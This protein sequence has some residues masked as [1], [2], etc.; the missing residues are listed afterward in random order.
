ML[1]SKFKLLTILLS[2]VLVWGLSIINVNAGSGV[3]LQAYFH[4]EGDPAGEL[5]VNLRQKLPDQDGY[6]LVETITT[7]AT[8]HLFSNLSAELEYD[9]VVNDVANY[10]IAY[11]QDNGLVNVY[12]NKIYQ[13]ELTFP[14]GQVE[15]EANGLEVT[16]PYPNFD[17]VTTLTWPNGQTTP[18]ANIMDDHGKITINGAL[19]FPIDQPGLYSLTITQVDLKYQNFS[20]DDAL[21]RVDYLVE[22]TGFDLSVDATVVFKDEAIAPAI[23]FAN[24]YTTLPIQVSLPVA[25]AT[26]KPISQAESFQI[27]LYDILPFGEFLNT[28]VT[29]DYPQ[30]SSSAFSFMMWPGTDY[31]VKI[32]QIPNSSPYY[33]Y[34]Q[35]SYLVNLATDPYGLVDMTIFDGTS[36]SDQIIFTNVYQPV[37]TEVTVPF[38]KQILNYPANTS[39]TFEFTLEA[40]D[41]QPGATIKNE[42]VALTS[43]GD[44]Q[45]GAFDLEF[46]EPGTYCFTLAESPGALDNYRYDNSQYQLEAIVSDQSGY[47]KVVANYYLANQAVTD[48]VFTNEYH[49]EPI[50]VPDSGANPGL[51]EG[52]ELPGGEQPI[53]DA[54]TPAITTPPENVVENETGTKMP[55]SNAPIIVT[56]DIAP[57]SINLSLLTLG[58][59]ALA[60]L[61]KP[62][63][64]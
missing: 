60:W 55:S 63:V 54:Q 36:F 64:K 33:Q 18:L 27:G 6:L 28:S 31:N 57:I 45:H 58:L 3:S 9:V 25:I 7:S 59:L 26:D 11:Q 44:L 10:N 56:G 42:Q 12:L 46:T 29:I 62:Q 4:W 13:G 23:V 32:S 38:A 17:F 14:L 22:A 49:L 8:S 34:D 48:I 40:D 2:L 5:T 37:A 15:F 61:R 47:L 51:E 19:N 43:L 52:Q 30:D 35:T 39:P 41:F 1:Q 53:P 16:T 50:P 24:S 20:F 21:Y